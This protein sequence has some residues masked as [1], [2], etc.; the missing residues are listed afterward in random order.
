MALEE[1]TKNITQGLSGVQKLDIKEQIRKELGK[2]IKESL[3]SL[4]KEFEA[5]YELSNVEIGVSVT[6]TIP[7]SLTGSVSATLTKRQKGTS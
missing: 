6:A 1:L 4:K 3:E 5:E 2:L 7:P